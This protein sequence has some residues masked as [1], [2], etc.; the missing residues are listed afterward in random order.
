MEELDDLK[1]KENKLQTEAEGLAK[2]TDRYSLKAEKA[3][4]IGDVRHMV[5]KSNSH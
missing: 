4:T 5:A 3:K 2:S 1:A